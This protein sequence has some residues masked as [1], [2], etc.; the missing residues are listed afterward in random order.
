MLYQLSNIGFDRDIKCSLCQFDKL[1]GFEKI[2]ASKN[3]QLTPTLTAL[4]NDTKSQ[5]PGD[6]ENGDVNA[7]VGIDLRWGLSQDAVINATINPDFSQVE[8]DS[9]ALD[10]NTTYSIYYEEKRPFFL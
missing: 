5:L 10:I 4:R 1:T 3:L 8:T 7:E 9:L 6:W 2:T